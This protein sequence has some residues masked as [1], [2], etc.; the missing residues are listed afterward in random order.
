MVLELWEGDAKEGA[1]ASGGEV[2][3]AG[4]ATICG[5]AREL[6]KLS[7]KSI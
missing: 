3:E 6:A 2:K 7:E 1:I 5:V 4:V